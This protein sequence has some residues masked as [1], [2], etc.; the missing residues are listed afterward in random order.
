[1]NLSRA[2]K[3]GTAISAL[4]LTAT[5]V[6]GQAPSK[7]AALRNGEI[8]FVLSQ[9]V[10]AMG[11]AAVGKACPDGLSISTND[12]YKKSLTPEAATAH[13]LA[14]KTALDNFGKGGSGFAGYYDARTHAEWKNSDGSF[15]CLKPQAAP[16]D[17]YFKTAVNVAGDRVPG[18]LQ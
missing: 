9:M 18:G 15:I 12:L 8:G 6:S 11:D 1:M 16:V 2:I 4:A 5:Q 10:P 7:P 13:D 3:L 14:L 17:P